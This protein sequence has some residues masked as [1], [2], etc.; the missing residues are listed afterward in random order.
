MNGKYL[1]EKI[2]E[3]TVEEILSLGKNESERGNIFEKLWDII[4]KFGFCRFFPNDTYE[5]YKGNMNITKL[6]KID[7]LEKYLDELSIFS[8]GEGGS[9]DITLKNKKD[10]RWI[11]I[12]SKFYV[13]D[14]KK[15]I[16]EYDIQKIV[17]A[18]NHNSDVYKEYHIY[19]LVKD[20]DKVLN[21]I[22]KCHSTNNYIK[23]KI[24]SIFDLKDLEKDFI[25]LQQYIQ[26]LDFN[27][28]DS[29]FS[30]SKIPLQLR[31]H[32]E[33]IC[34]KQ[35][36]KINERQKEMLI[37]AKP[38]SGKTYCIGGLF[39]KYYKKYGMLNA[40]IL[41][42][43]PNE[44]IPQF[45][46]DLFNKFLDFIEINVIE[47][48][49]G[50]DLLNIVLG[51]NNIIIVSKQLLDSY[52]LEKTVKSIKNLELDFIVSDE[53]HFHGTTQMSK[54]ILNSYSSEKTIKTYLT[55]TYFKSLNEWNISTDC[56]F[57]WDIEDEQLCKK[58]DVLSLIDKHG[59]DV[60]LFLN[61]NNQEDL[62]KVYDV[63]PSL[64][65]ITNMMDIERYDSIKERIKDTSYG[66]SNSTLLCGNF[67]REVDIV[68]AYIT[69][70]NKEQDYPN[71]DKSI[72]GRI[73]NR[74][75]KYNSR[76]KLNNG[77]FTTQLWFLPF[78]AGITIDKVSEH[79][80]ERMLNN[81]ILKKYEIKIINSKKDYKLKDIK[82]SIKKYEIRAKSQGRDGLILLA[83]NQLTLGVTLPFVDIVFLFNDTTSADKIFQ[84]M[85]RSMTERINDPENDLINIG[86]KHFGFVVD[87]N[88]SRV[89]NTVLQYNVKNGLN[90]EQKIQ[91]VVENNLINIDSDLFENKKNKSLLVERLIEIWRTNPVN[92]LSVLL[93]KIQN[94][95]VTLENSDQKMINKYFTSSKG[96]SKNTKVEADKDNVQRIQ[97]GKSIRTVSEKDHEKDH[98]N[99]KEIEI[100]FSKDVLPYIIP[101]CCIL[102]MKTPH[103]DILEIMEFI[104]KEPSLLSVLEEQCFIWWNKREVLKMIITLILK[105][106]KKDSDI[107][108]ITIQFKMS[109]KGLLDKPDELLKL[110]DSCLKPKQKEKKEFGEV[111][112]PMELVNEMLD[113]LD[114]YYKEK[115]DR[116]IFTEADFKWGDI[117]GCGMGN[118]S[119][120]IYLR[121]MEGL[122]CEFP[123]EDIRKRHILEN[124]IYMAE[125]NKK[126]VFI[127][128]QIFD[129]DSYRLNLFEGDSLL[130]D[131]NVEWGI[132]KFDVIIG[133]PPYNRGGIRSHTG[134]Q[135]GEK[136]ETIWTKFVQKSFKCL[137]QDGYLV[138]INPLSW[139]KKS[140]SLHNVM[141]NMHIIWLK[142][143]DDSKSKG[144]INADIPISLYILQN[145]I[146]NQNKRTEI[147]SEIKRK[148]LVTSSNEYLNKKYSIPLA[149]HSI[150]NKLITFIESRNLQL[151]YSTK[152]IKSSGIKT[153]IPSNYILEDMLAVDTYTL[154]E[155]ILTKKATEVHQDAN[156][157]KIIIAN[158]RGFKGAFI[159]EG[160]L[161]L[162]GNHKF[163]ILGDKLEL[164]QKL[165]E[166]N[167]SHIA[168]DYLKYG[169]SFLDNEAFKYI[170]DIRKLGINDITEDEFYKLIQ[171]TTEE[172]EQIKRTDDVSLN[173]SEE[174]NVNIQP[175]RTVSKSTTNSGDKDI[176]INN[177][178]PYKFT[179]GKKQ[180][181]NC[182]VKPK[183]GVYCSSHKKYENTTNESLRTVSKSSSKST[184]KNLKDKCNILGL[185]YKSKDKK[186][187]L[188][189]K[190]EKYNMDTL[191]E[192]CSLEDESKYT[193]PLEDV[194][195]KDVEIGKILKDILEN[196][197][198]YNE[199]IKKLKNIH[200][201][202]KRQIDNE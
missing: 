166:F 78:G 171:I 93:K 170:P 168:S 40:L 79:L 98:E 165:L 99:K 20:R 81:L 195:Y 118:F 45:T 71:G 117:A 180:G 104:E 32:Q 51:Q 50:N 133:N 129:G 137:K 130:L 123:D 125:L 164:I 159:D 87:L 196:K 150:F 2:K 100:S 35:M 109:L 77:D 6:K 116:S 24:H 44:T 119:V 42:P 82:E 191:F 91:Y 11:F 88:I 72:F 73:K 4:I 122:K 161:S 103:T 10:G 25:R 55:A 169:Q 128:N 154:Q 192:Y 101:L 173:I 5:H 49:C 31:F 160:K 85:Y 182:G 138:F 67:P 38:R 153:K 80:K 142:L 181:E 127:C 60:L 177:C 74:C 65:M 102:T 8:K 143:W 34:Y 184:V 199:F 19:L 63:M 112:T 28:I 47:I 115:N 163:Y 188:M 17:A 56:Q 54:N 46:D 141:L 83:G 200:P 97:S 68:L 30:K 105:Y 185:K 70:S 198:K 64:E 108:N 148:K 92:Y 113:K 41:T 39:I 111:F 26:N 58:R 157:R 21:T 96:D 95:N 48:K 183:N 139:L 175:L 13:D 43:C 52:V 29:I 57:F 202:I 156:K 106:I 1:F 176:Q 27:K 90:I 190:I 186:S 149:Y 179:K 14:D 53:N 187:D 89:L 69:G 189:E 61:E 37:G 155:G 12:S 15:S 144:I 36:K 193:L 62:L 167:I 151:E 23:E 158:K 18:I 146:N 194:I 172:I 110:I 22:S 201:R 7:Y 66:F 114:K 134:K 9:S 197:E 33:L 16:D 147:I 126:N 140:H 121:L 120:G 124:M 136:N 131:P 86:K 84:M 107:Y 152:T 59:D 162:T 75:T 132:D 76:T 178:C 135:L 94:C 174:K 3:Y 145:I